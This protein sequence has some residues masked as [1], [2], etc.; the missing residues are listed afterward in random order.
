MILTICSSLANMPFRGVTS[1]QLQCVRLPARSERITGT[2]DSNTNR[3]VDD[4]LKQR[5]EVQLYEDITCR[6][7]MLVED[8]Y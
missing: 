7:H 2:D 4:F 8:Y 5:E 3:H 6:V 1:H